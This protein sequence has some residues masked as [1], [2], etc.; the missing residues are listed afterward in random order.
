[1]W[2]FGLIQLAWISRFLIYVLWSE[3]GSLSG[4]NRCIASGEPSLDEEAPQ[5]G[6]A[7]VNYGDGTQDGDLRF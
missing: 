5:E 4:P 3:E 7:F 6:A 1:M 2:L